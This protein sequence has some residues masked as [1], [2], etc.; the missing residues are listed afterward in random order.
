M[1]NMFADFSLFSIFTV[2]YKFLPVN[3]EV[4]SWT[5]ITV[6]EL[7]IYIYAYTVLLLNFRTYCAE[8]ILRAP[9]GGHPQKHVGASLDNF[10]VSRRG[11]HWQGHSEQDCS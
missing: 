6:N 5:I 7:D 4:Y 9:S 1:K 8:R 10:D 2:L 11:E 3:S